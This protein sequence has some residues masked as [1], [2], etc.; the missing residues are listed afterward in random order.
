M[1]KTKTEIQVE[2]A[3]AFAEMSVINPY[4]AGSWQNAAWAAGYSL[5]KAGHAAAERAL[6]EERIAQ[7]VTMPRAKGWDK[8]D[9]SVEDNPRR[10]YADVRTKMAALTTRFTRRANAGLRPS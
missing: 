1:A 4:K 2:G 6:Y 3:Q 5:A 10:V 7:P 9:T 8:I